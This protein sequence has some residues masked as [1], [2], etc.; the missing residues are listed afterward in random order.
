MLIPFSCGY[1]FDKK[2]KYIIEY[3][4]PKDITKIN[5][6]FSGCS[7]LT[8]IDLSHFNTHNIENMSY[9]FFDCNC[10][11]KIYLPHLDTQNVKD[12]SYMFTHCLSLTDI[13]LS[14]FN[15]EMLRI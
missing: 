4:L 1:K 15:T 8:S 7:Y 9:M 11:K 6:L 14:C 5:H 2:G 3:S 10:L 13:N 12:M